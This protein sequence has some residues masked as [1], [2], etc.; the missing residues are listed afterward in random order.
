MIRPKDVIGRYKSPSEGW[1][2]RRMWLADTK[3]VLGDRPKD[4]T[5]DFDWL[6]RIFHLGDC[7]KDAQKAF[8]WPRRRCRLGDRPKDAPKAFDWSRR[9]NFSLWKWVWL[10][11]LPDGSDWTRREPCLF[12]L[13][14]T[15]WTVRW[16]CLAK[17][18]SD[19]PIRQSASS[20]FFGLLCHAMS[21]NQTRFTIKLLRESVFF[22]RRMSRSD[23]FLTP[24]QTKQTSPCF[25]CSTRGGV[26]ILCTIP[27]MWLGKCVCV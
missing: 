10:V 25:T 11:V 20:V 22:G 3:V 2:V 18:A 7:P 12:F 23:L 17:N 19:W 14:A 8:D 6:R 9:S 13:D 24:K 1:S 16:T 5:K 4:A 15:D 21:D 26:Y 27:M